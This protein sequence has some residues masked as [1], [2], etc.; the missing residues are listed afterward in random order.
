MVKKKTSGKKSGS[1]KKK[2]VKKSSAEA[3]AKKPSTL[4]LK[5]ETEIAMD[6]AT[7][8]YKKFNKLIKSVIL[9]GSVAKQEAEA[10]SDI[11]III[12]I[13]DASIKWDLE[14]VAWYREELDKILRANPY[15]KELHINTIKLTTWWEDLMRGDPLIINIIRYGEE[16]IDFGGFF[17]PL[18]F[19]L[20]NGKIRSTPEAIYNAL[21]RAPMHITRSKAAALGAIE[22]VYWSMVDSAHAAL[23][24]AKVLP[25][26]PEHI[27]EELNVNFV[28]KGMLNEK[29]V[30]W[31]KEIL[32]LYKQI[33]H[34][35]IRTLKGVEIDKWQDRAEEFLRVMATLVERLT[36]VKD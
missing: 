20:V 5:T 7:K 16:M 18:K 19:L 24:A 14:L 9:F 25:P 36:R 35:K 15:Q 10:G 21:Q 1:S 28:G 33:T 8:V 2:S 30:D 34:G 17:K 6:F 22:G 13:D 27:V 12:V 4:E 23:I 3:S 26:S 11:D 32:Y 31:Y 29:Y